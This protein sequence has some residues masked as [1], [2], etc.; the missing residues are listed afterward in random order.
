VAGTG[1]CC[2]SKSSAVAVTCW[3]LPWRS[4]FPATGAFLGSRLT[5]DSDI[6][7]LIP[8]GNK[9]VDD[10]KDAVA[11]FGS[12]SYLVL[13]LEAGEQA[14][15][16]ELED[17][18]DA[19]AERLV[20]LDELVEM[21]EHRLDPGADFLDLFYDNALLYLHPDRLADLEARL[22]T[23][24]IQD[25]MRQNR[26]SLSSPTAAF[27]QELMVNDP[28][29]LMP[30]LFRPSGN[31]GNLRVDLSDGYYLSQDGKS[32]IMLVKPTGPWQDLDFD[33]SLM[34][35][36]RDVEHATREQLKQEARNEANEAAEIGIRYTGRY[37]IAVDE[38]GLVRQDI[39]FNLLASLFAVSA[40]Y[41][42]CYR[43]FAA[44]LYSS[45]PLLVGQAMTFGAAFFLLPI[46]SGS[47]GLNAA[48]SA[49]TAR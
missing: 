13:L 21:V 41:W 17:F 32:L 30:L 37:A 1:S 40:L 38:A 19:L 2:D 42:L 36:V 34:Q 39:K 27:T 5:V 24:A 47:R 48:S 8:A 45:V 10:F 15:P 6:L 12:I 22:E 46:V 23:E 28:L 7:A 20:A 49:F 31:L 29:N 18:A 25:R 11:D 26:L 43:R 44:L 35:A 4:R 3:C 33:V 9:Q 16:D 14:G